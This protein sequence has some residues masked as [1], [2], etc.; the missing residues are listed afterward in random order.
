[1]T[2]QAHGKAARH[3]VAIGLWAFLLASLTSLASQMGAE[4]IELF[5]VGVILLLVVIFVGIVFDIVGVAATAARETPLHARAARR[6]FGARHAVWLVRNAHQVASFCN[7]VVGDVSGT[8]SG[9]IGVTLVLKLLD[10]PTER[11]LVLGISLMTACIAAL[12]VG[13]KAYGKVLAI[14]RGTEIM[15]RTGQLVACLDRVLPFDLLAR[16]RR[17]RAALS[18]RRR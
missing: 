8:L 13:G 5:A 11:E 12:V 3:A 9:A 14:E 4:R 18:A 2:R 16:L 15:F 10:G 6:V 17:Q 7:D 1:M